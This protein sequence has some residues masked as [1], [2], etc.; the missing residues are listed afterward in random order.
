MPTFCIIQSSLLFLSGRK[1]LREI[2]NISWYCF[3]S[4]Y[5]T[6][7]QH[8][9]ELFT[10][11]IR[12]VVF[13]YVDILRVTFSQGLSTSPVNCTTFCSN[14]GMGSHFVWIEQVSS[15]KSTVNL[16]LWMLNMCESDIQVTKSWHLSQHLPTVLSGASLLH[17]TIEGPKVTDYTL[18][19]NYSLPKWGHDSLTKS[20]YLRLLFSI[21][22]ICT[23]NKQVKTLPFSDSCCSPAFSVESFGLILLFRTDVFLSVLD[24]ACL[25]VGFLVYNEKEIIPDIT[26]VMTRRAHT[27]NLDRNSQ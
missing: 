18:T 22:K 9:L 7:Q 1:V 16:S 25:D 14:C 24:G 11:R 8:D 13:F 23:I 19:V 12:P 5:F 10:K 21:C 6:T 17:R 4:Y 27:V 26:R 20:T 3:K 15:Y 2:S